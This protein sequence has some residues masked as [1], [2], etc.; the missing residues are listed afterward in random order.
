LAAP[1]ATDALEIGRHSVTTGDDRA[2]SLALAVDESGPSPWL[3]A[4]AEALPVAIA[5]WPS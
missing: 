1:N 3:P 2:A 5:P 4:Q